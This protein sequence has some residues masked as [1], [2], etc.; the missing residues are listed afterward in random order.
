MTTATAP[1]RSPG[2]RRPALGRSTA[3]RLAATE[4]DRFTAHLH[5]LPVE[6]WS[7]PTACPDWDVHAMACHILGMVEMSASVR[8]Q[9]RQMR[10]AT[11][12]SKRDGGLFIDALT[13]LQVREHQ[14]MAPAQIV[15]ALARTGPAA[16]KG[17]A[18]TPALMRRLVTMTQPVD[19]A[20]TV[21]ETWT[22]GYLVDTILTRDPWMHRSDLAEATGTAMELTADHDGI[23]IADVANE[24][25][26]R[27]GHPCTLRLTGPVGGE[28][29][30]G[31]GGPT[32]ESDAVDFAR[33]LAGRRPADGLLATP[34]PF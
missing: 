28:W 24:W 19:A 6:A 13:S 12:V 2:K 5:R 9:R 18:R 32:I 23:L 34:V 8:E 3:M 14:E 17:R 1:Q 4:Y 27:H 16:A 25:A 7:A 10:T 20:G 22:L 30:W 33:T 29:T 31:E 11:R 21:T 26:D 15:E